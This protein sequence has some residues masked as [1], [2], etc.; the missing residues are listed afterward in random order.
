MYLK[1]IAG[2]SHKSLH[3]RGK[4]LPVSL[5]HKVLFCTNRVLCVFETLTDRQILY[6]YLNSAYKLL[7]NSPI[8]VR[9]P[10][11]KVK[12]C[13]PVLSDAFLIASDYTLYFWQLSKQKVTSS[14]RTIRCN[15]THR[16]TLH[17]CTFFVLRGYVECVIA[18]ES[19]RL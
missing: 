3:F 10:K 16:L 8:E 13:F 5:V 6:T 9:G 11:K 18:R 19:D 4:F 7:L 14:S 1:T 15:M 12:F 17:I 2:E